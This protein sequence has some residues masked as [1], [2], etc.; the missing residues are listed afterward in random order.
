LL[1]RTAPISEADRAKIAHENAE[2]L[3]HLSK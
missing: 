3:L 1:L 2:K